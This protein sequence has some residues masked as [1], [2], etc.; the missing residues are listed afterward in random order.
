MADAKKSHQTRT[1]RLEPGFYVYRYLC[2]GDGP[3][4]VV[5]L[6]FAPG[7]DGG[8]V[9][10]LGS[11]R[12]GQ[13][14]LQKYGDMA[15]V[16][17]AGA[18]GVIGLSL[19]I[20]N[21]FP[22]RAVHLEVERL[23]AEPPQRERHDNGH[24]SLVTLSGHIEL[25]GEVEAGFGD[26]LGNPKLERRLEG[27]SVLWPQRP[28]G[29]DISYRCVVAGMGE[30]P[31]VLTGGFAGTRRRA[32]PLRSI[33]FELVG[34]RSDHFTIATEAA[35]AKRGIV[36]GGDGEKLTG[37]GNSDFLVALKVSV[38]AKSEADN[39]ATAPHNSNRVKTF[40]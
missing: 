24:D 6:G 13:V 5:T 36:H 30:S 15:V 38:R 14:A 28:Y 10:L 40:R 32:M 9:N 25:Q 29:V 23:E 1:V 8:E 31:S 22:Q 11:K 27:F 21:G 4:P 2:E 20:P 33:I 17:V 35:F 34:E 3:L 39:S 12:G 16:H 7:G 26:W 18:A 37:L 19:F